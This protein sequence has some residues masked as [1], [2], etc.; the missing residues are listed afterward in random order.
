M[1][2]SAYQGRNQVIFN[3]ELFLAQNPALFAT[4]QGRNETNGPGPAATMS[5]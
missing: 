4:R 5:N 3:N 1:L 2:T